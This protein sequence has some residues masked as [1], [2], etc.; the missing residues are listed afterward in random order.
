MP[1]SETV[2]RLIDET[3]AMRRQGFY[4]DALERE[5]NILHHLSIMAT[6]APPDLS[7]LYRREAQIKQD[8]RAVKEALT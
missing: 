1:A 5:Q 6:D 8:L 4:V 7:A 3:L 2:Q